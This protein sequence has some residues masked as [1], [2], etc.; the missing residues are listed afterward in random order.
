MLVAMN[1]ENVRSV[2]DLIEARRMGVNPKYVFFWGH[3]PRPDGQLSASCFSQW[4][5]ARFSADG[6]DFESAEH[7]MMWRKATLF[8]DST[9]TE[10]ILRARSPAHAKAIGR[11]VA[12]FDEA[13]WAEHRWGIVVNASVAKFG[14][15]RTLSAYLLGTGNRVLVEASPQ[16]RIWGIGLTKDSPVADDPEQWR[17]LNLLGFALMEARERLGS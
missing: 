15:D 14:S 7:Y 8:G 6:Q 12:G 10:Q 17:G 16:D 11:E 9:R 2:E 4:W 1:A 13:V 3:R 5:P